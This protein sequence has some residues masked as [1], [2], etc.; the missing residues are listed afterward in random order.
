MKNVAT[1]SI[2]KSSTHDTHS[3]LSGHIH[4][5]AVMVEI[6]TMNT[7]KQTATWIGVIF[8]AMRIPLFS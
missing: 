6:T 1:A 7:Q 4:A 3:G 2:T 8:A 5:I